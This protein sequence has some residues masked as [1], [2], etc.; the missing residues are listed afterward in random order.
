MKHRFGSPYMSF[1]VVQMSEIMLLNSYRWIKALSQSP[2][3]SF[4]LDTRKLSRTWSLHSPN[5]SIGSQILVKVV[6]HRPLYGQGH[7]FHCS[8]HRSIPS[9]KGTPLSSHRQQTVL[10]LTPSIS[11]SPFHSCTPHH[12]S[13]HSETQYHSF[14]SL[15][16]AFP[17][18]QV[19]GMA[20]WNCFHLTTVSNSLIR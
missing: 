13:F 14:H 7:P 16:H 10:H 20:S 4:R 9:N 5:A 8:I 6:R 11:L 1:G 12:Y 17:R 19:S 2:W 15:P 18:V 3:A